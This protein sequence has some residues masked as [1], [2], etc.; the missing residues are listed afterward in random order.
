MGF[1]TAC[2]ITIKSNKII[3][4][5]G[6]LL[7]YQIKFKRYESFTDVSVSAFVFCQCETF[8]GHDHKALSVM[9]GRKAPSISFPKL[10]SFD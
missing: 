4:F 8:Y 10:T 9:L 1:G 3:P 7:I 6:P 5:T 2:R